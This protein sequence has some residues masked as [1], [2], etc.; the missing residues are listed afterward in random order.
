[1]SFLAGLWMDA[2]EKYKPLSAVSETLKSRSLKQ[3]TLRRSSSAEFWGV[4]L[5]RLSQLD[6][7]RGFA[8]SSVLV[9][10]LVPILGIGIG[11]N[12]VAKALYRLLIPGWLGVDVFFVLSGF[13][14][15]GI[16]LKERTQPDF[17]SNFYLR[18]GF[19]ILP[20]FFAIFTLTLL[21]AHFYLPVVHISTTYVLMS[22]FFLANWA[23]DQF[24][25]LLHIWSL[26]VEEQFYF[27]WPQGCRHLDNL[28]I[29]KLA[30]A[31]ASG[32]L[33]LRVG[34]AFAHVNPYTIYEITP[35][36]IDGISCGAAL[37][38]GIT[39]PRVHIF[40]ARYWRRIAVVA[41]TALPVIFVLLHGRLNGFDATSQMLA[42]PPA[43]V[44]AAM[45]IFGAVESTLPT[46]L[47][48]FFGNPLMT[49][50]G[51]R[52]YGLYLIHEPL[53]VAVT[54]S[55]DHG[56]L[57]V[58]PSGVGANTILAL[59]VLAASL[60]LTE[61]SWRLIESPAQNLR[62]R[63]MRNKED[64]TKAHPSE[65]MEIIQVVEETRLRNPIQ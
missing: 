18:R 15:T 2:H 10:H 20:A 4:C 16:I 53:R 48:R 43:V 12:M 33:L 3:R 44:L 65:E 40:L 31:L 46:A 5:K 59:S 47:S 21:A 34:L 63:L 8:V 11:K 27:L 36:R 51:K 64:G 6:G 52:S 30:L 57:A 54:E 28:K 26:A 50:L 38:A 7:I 56:S 45:L 24:P 9:C 29:F 37:A 62:R 55:R 13:L 35:T 17:W 25:F 19:R 23:P 1:V 58:L 49:Y 39:L 32:S 22:T 60:I 41:G 61:I 14:I 42:I